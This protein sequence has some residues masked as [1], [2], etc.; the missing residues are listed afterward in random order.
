MDRRIVGAAGVKEIGQDVAVAGQDG[1]GLGLA[2]NTED[3]RG[4]LCAPEVA[5]PGAEHR[6]RAWASGATIVSIGSASEI[7]AL[8]TSDSVNSRG[9]RA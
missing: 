6:R 1:R 2:G 7:A 3:L 5:A 9:A 8:R 4:Q